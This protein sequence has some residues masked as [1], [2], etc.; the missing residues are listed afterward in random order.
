MLNYILKEKT[1]Y[2]YKL[3]TGRHGVALMPHRKKVLGSNLPVNW[4]LSV[5]VH[6]VALSVW[7]TWPWNQTLL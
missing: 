2:I 6:A 5:Y 1:I 4:G 3:K 7:E